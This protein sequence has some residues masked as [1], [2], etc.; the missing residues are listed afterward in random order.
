[1]RTEFPRAPGGSAKDDA[2]GQSGRGVLEG[3]F[4]LLDHLGTMGEAGLTRLSEAGNVPKATAYRLLEQLTALGAVE[5]NNGQYRVG[6]RIFSLG[7]MWRP[8]P[9]LRRAAHDP[10]LRM[11]R[12]TGTSVGVA[13]LAYGQVVTLGVACGE[14]ARRVPMEAGMPLPRRTAAA[15]MLLAWASA[16]GTESAVG[17]YAAPG[18]GPGIMS[19][20][21]AE[22][23]RGRGAAFDREGILPGVNCVAVPLLGPGS[24]TPI[25]ALYAVGGT[26]CPLP[27]LAADLDRTSAVISAAIPDRPGGSTA[28]AHS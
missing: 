28:G 26:S 27:R 7:R 13:V 12:A 9:E 22:H 24:S 23:L 18:P 19:P 16:P 20:A 8:D 14:A 21:H 11:A 3:A 1:M 6:A 2:V 15:T 17:P 4:T 5:K 10:M 25:A